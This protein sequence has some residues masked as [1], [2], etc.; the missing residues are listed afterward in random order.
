MSEHLVDD[1]R[2]REEGA[3]A[4]DLRGHILTN[5]SPP[6]LALGDERRLVLSIVQS[7]LQTDP[8]KKS[9]HTRSRQ[10]KPWQPRARFGS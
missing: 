8:F 1:H 10:L 7:L 4:V 5:R 9:L 2:P 6:N 3:L